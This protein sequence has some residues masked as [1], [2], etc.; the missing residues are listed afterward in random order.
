M[1]ASASRAL[2]REGFS[3]GSIRSG[4][5]GGFVA[6]FIE[7]GDGSA[8]TAFSGL[9]AAGGIDQDVAHGAL[10]DTD[11]RSDDGGDGVF[12]A[13]KLGGSRFR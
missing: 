2:S 5:D 12:A 13:G 11:T 10:G 4:K 1:R 9:A 3:S 6:E 8:T 7:A